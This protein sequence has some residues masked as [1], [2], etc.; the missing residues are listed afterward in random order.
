MWVSERSQK[1]TVLD[2]AAQ[3]GHVTMPG[4]PVGVYLDGERRELPLYGPGGYAWRPA[5][6]AQVLVIKA[7]GDGEEPCVVGEQC[8]PVSLKEGEI[9]IY[10]GKAA[11]R[12]NPD[13]IVNVTGALQV[14]GR[15]VLTEG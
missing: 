14:N 9:L 2:G 10:T 4:N 5:G 12:V 3:V 7:G 1:R 13:G 8:Q 11:I 6:A 15:S